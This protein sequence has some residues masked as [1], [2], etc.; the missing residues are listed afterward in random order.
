MPDGT[1]VDQLYI[2][3]S[4]KAVKANDAIDRLCGKLD[5]LS[6]SLRKV[7]GAQLTGLATGVQR[8]GSAMNTM[9][10]IKTADFTRLATNLSKMGNIDV[11]K[12]N[13]AAVSISHIGKAINNIGPVSDNAQKFGEL[14]KGI[15][16]L[17]YKSSTK[18]IDNIPKLAIA[19]RD[20]MATLSK[21]PKV[22]QNL[23]DMTNALAKLARTGASSGRA[24]NSLSKSFNLFSSSSKKAKT[25]SF[26]LAS[27]M[28]KVYATYW[29]L[30]RAFS[31]LKDAID[32]SSKLTEVQ[33]VVDVTFGKYRN[34][35][36]DM[37]KTSITDF[38]MSELTVKEVSSRFQAMGTAM[39]IANKKVVSSSEFLAKKGVKAYGDLGSSM[40]DV[41][42]NLT[43]LTA[44]MASFYNVEQ[45]DVAEDLT[46]I[47]SGQTRPLR[48][49]G[50][51]LT[52][53]TLKEFALKNGID[54]NIKS[55]SQAEK[56]MLRYQYVMANTG[57]AQGDFARTANT[58]ANQVRILKQNFEALG[59]VV[60]GTLINV[61]K[62]IVSA[63]NVVI[64]K[65]IQFA[66]VVSESLGKI[67]GWEYQES[68]VSG[69]TNEMEDAADASSG[70]A[71]GLDNAKNNA[72]KLKQQLQGFDELNVLSSDKD[73]STPNNSNTGASGTSGTGDASSGKWEKTESIF[74][75]YES[76]LDSLYKLG[77]YIGTTLTNTLN[78][79]N[80]ENVYE[81]AKHFGS[82]LASF[83]N[84]LISPELFGA[85]GQ[86]IAGSINTA[87][88]VLNSFAETFEWKEFGKSLARGLTRFFETWDAKL[89]GETFSNFVRGILQSLTG[90]FETLSEDETFRTI[91]QKIVDFICG[92]NWSGLL[93]DFGSLGIAF[94]KSVIDGLTGFAEGMA[95]SVEEKMAPVWENL[96][97][98]FKENFKF[99]T[100]EI[101]TFDDLKSNFQEMING[102]K[103][104]W[105]DNVNLPEIKAPNVESIKEKIQEKWNHAKDWWNDKKEKLN[106]VSVTINSI[107]ENLKAKWDYAKNWWKNKREKLSNVSV[108][109]NS[110]YSK[111]KEKWDYAKTWWKKKSALSSVSISVKSIKDKLKSAWTT[112]RNWWNKNKPSLSE[113]TAKIKL[114][115]LVVTWDT[116]TT[117]AKALQKLGLKGF[118]NFS[119]KYY[120]MGGFPEDGWFRANHGELM[121]KFD[122]GRTVVANNKQI[123]QGIAEAVYQ[124][125]REN[126]ALLRQELELM[127]RQ[128]NLLSDILEKE[129]GISAG[130]LFSSVRQSAN[131][132]KRRTGRPAFSY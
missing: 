42:V 106:N 63:L 122:N 62:P 29:L 5:R 123:T 93:W 60:G 114:P 97:N 14:A 52:E 33:N 26:S 131:D 8:L 59:T 129:T 24:V 61:F 118:P 109:V 51:D 90:F 56:T 113:I 35:V 28:G 22:S 54:A 21:A 101:P 58:W 95:D 73:S 17:G 64:G 27:A 30:F 108:S 132:Y 37:S 43:K 47:F 119:V 2:D 3:I 11:G 39:G 112:A 128:N 69:V 89:T 75:E 117:A 4:A 87:L 94:F 105:N 23:I 10:Q 38:G 78:N 83:L 98:W 86:T 88:H 130:E 66:K 72:K 74:K 79:I 110:I 16:Q 91:G 111:L 65:F 41:S 50:L 120:A 96:D 20:L 103:T 12:L 18:A 57:A 121:G 25:S 44:D 6:T 100:P 36:E 48:T 80:W 99:K 31:K 46:A 68:G 124:G 81:G 104:W 125:N 76:S 116:S 34:I 70:V 82:G 9:N 13:S 84:G 85:L 15:A 127:R 7:N 32:I 45:K 67:F 40:A 55:M 53:A 107:Y 71:D 115:R 126:N 77:E 92:I 102:L 49:Y 19:M 1:S